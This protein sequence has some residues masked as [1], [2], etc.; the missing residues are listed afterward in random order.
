[1]D[2]GSG[3]VSAYV[4]DQI[5]RERERLSFYLLFRPREVEYITINEV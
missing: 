2:L 4:P 3:L 5:L 1:M